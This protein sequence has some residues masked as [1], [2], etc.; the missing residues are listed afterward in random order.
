MPVRVEIKWEGDAFQR[1]LRDAIVAGIEKAAESTA[2]RAR[3]LVSRPNPDG[4]N[5]SAPGEPPKL[6]T[7]DLR[8]SIGSTV[9]ESEGNVTG[10]VFAGAPY[11][12]RLEFGFVGRDSLGRSYGQ[13]PR[14]FLRPALLDR[15]GEIMAQISAEV[16][17]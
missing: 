9:Q 1:K 6:V 10:I 5:P 12:R 4:R 11:A 16:K 14:P 8:E 7:G 15:R 3:E 2:E 13:A 17:G